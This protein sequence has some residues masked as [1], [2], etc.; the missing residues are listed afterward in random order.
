MGRNYL[1][2]SD[3]GLLQWSSN[4]AK[5][6]LE[7]AEAYSLTQE[8]AEQYESLQLAYAS[9]YRTATTWATRGMSTVCAKNTARAQLI[10][11]TRR[12][13]RIVQVVDLTDQERIDLGLT[14]RQRSVAR[15]PTPEE[16]PRLQVRS[17][18][19]RVVKLLV[20]RGPDHRGRARPRGSGG[21]F[22]Y[23]FVGEDWAADPKAWNIE[24]ACTRATCEIEFPFTIPPGSRVWL[25]AAWLSTRLQPGKRSSPIHTTLAGGVARLAA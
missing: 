24:T 14:V 20:D 9:A 22:I 19:G 23:S 3:S 21:A 10:A 17:V 5:Y 16:S 13:V 6:I 15:L 4:F 18:D 2:D 12:L 11:E 25:C 8:Q 7:D 1:P